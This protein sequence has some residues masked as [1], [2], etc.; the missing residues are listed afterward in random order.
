MTDEQTR[1]VWC[2]GGREIVESAVPWCE[3]HNQPML[4]GVD[5]CYPQRHEAVFGPC[6]LQDPPKVWTET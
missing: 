5:E 2:L 4:P 3:T 1:I 6:K